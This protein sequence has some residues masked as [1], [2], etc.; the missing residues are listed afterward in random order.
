MDTGRHT[1]SHRE[2]GNH[3]AIHAG[4]PQ[5]LWLTHGTT[6]TTSLILPP[7][8]AVM[9]LTDL[10]NVPSS[11]PWEDGRWAGASY[12]SKLNRCLDTAVHAFQNLGL[13]VPEHVYETK[14]LHSLFHYLRTTVI[15]ALGIS[16]EDVNTVHFGD[17]YAVYSLMDEGSTFYGID[18]SEI[19]ASSLSKKGKAA[20]F[21]IAS[22]LMNVSGLVH[23]LDY[24]E[25][26]IDMIKEE[27]EEEGGD[28]VYLHGGQEQV[29][30]E[31]FMKDVE[32][33]K[34]LNKK[35]AFVSR[36][37]PETVIT[38][39]ENSGLEVEIKKMLLDFARIIQE[40]GSFHLYGEETDS[41]IDPDIFFAGYMFYITNS[42]DNLV[43][44]LFL[45]SVWEDSQNYYESN[46]RMKIDY[47]L[48]EFA[49]AKHI[50]TL[51]CRFRKLFKMFI[52]S[53]PS[54]KTPQ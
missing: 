15:E 11:L 45:S 12:R 17:E 21:G 9:Q 34:K 19:A 51:L 48:E 14:S 18:L 39:I 43:T 3:F 49:K 47:K 36:I 16:E 29:D 1:Q 24:A 37:N 38:R 10:S 32:Q 54:S 2:G 5:P 13:E 46:F 7:A 4:E 25:S 27:F 44:E 28:I 20:Y 30:T 50:S 23:V 33:M 42:N 41:E 53:I 6:D 8:P 35:F 22:L 31:D 52:M 26:A 40:I